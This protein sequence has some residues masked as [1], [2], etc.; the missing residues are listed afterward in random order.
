MLPRSAGGFGLG[1]IRTGSVMRLLRV[2]SD[3]CGQGGLAGLAEATG[4]R[5]MGSTGSR[6]CGVFPRW[7]AGSWHLATPER[8]D[9]AHHPAAVGAWLSQC[10]RDDLGGGCIVLR[11]RF[12][13][14]QRADLRDVGLAGGACQQAVVAD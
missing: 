3:H 4:E 10:Q 6:S 7:S 14:Q 9:D 13:A 1:L 5:W 11:G 12:L 2:F 8:L